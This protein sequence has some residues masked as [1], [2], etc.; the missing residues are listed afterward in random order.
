[1]FDV[2]QHRNAVRRGLSG[3]SVIGV[4]VLALLLSG[5]TRDDLF[6]PFYVSSVA[7]T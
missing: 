3:A 6:T 5:C 7:V 2:Q 4:L 1:M